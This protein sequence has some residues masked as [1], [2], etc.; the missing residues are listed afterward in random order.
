[1]SDPARQRRRT[2]LIGGAL[3]VL[4]AVLALVARG[5]LGGLYFAKDAFWALGVLV[6]VIGLGRAGSVTGR[7]PFAT[8]VVIAQVLVANPL[9]A[10]L[11]SGLVLDDPRN[12]HAE[13]DSWGS[14]FFPYY[15]LVFVLT[16]LAVIVVGWVRAVPSP[17]S[18][19]PAWVLASSW[20]LGALSV[21]LFSAAPLGTPLATFGAYLG[22][23]SAALGTMFLGVVAIVLGAR[24]TTAQPASVD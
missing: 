16:V 19:A 9:T 10:L 7:R 13:E 17:W 6:L 4:S 12:P 3:L 8:A 14:I 15:V 23:V 1:M 5:P 22:V 2:W 20:V 18:W 11:L 24:T 21:T